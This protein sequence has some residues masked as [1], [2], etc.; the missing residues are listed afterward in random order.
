[1]NCAVCGGPATVG[2]YCV[3]CLDGELERA[4][5]EELEAAS[6]IIDAARAE[7]QPF[8]RLDVLFDGVPLPGMEWVVSNLNGRLALIALRKRRKK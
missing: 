1:M 5:P 7:G 6:E 3:P 8:K 2:R 4:F